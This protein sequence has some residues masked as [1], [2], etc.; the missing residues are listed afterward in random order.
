MSAY[1]I[2]PLTRELRDF[3]YPLVR[4]ADPAISLD[5]WTAYVAEIADPLRFTLDQDEV[6]VA[7]D[8]GAYARGLCISAVR[9]HL[10]HGRL[11]DVSLMVVASAGDEGG[12][13]DR[14]MAYLSD[15]SERLGCDAIRLPAGAGAGWTRRV[16]ALAHARP[17][18]HLVLRPAWTAV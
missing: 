10:S 12:V 11:L 15:K 9:R 2:S 6:V 13:A 4:A 1:A 7:Q 14:L 16:P 8:E 3:V 18:Q 17:E 5:A